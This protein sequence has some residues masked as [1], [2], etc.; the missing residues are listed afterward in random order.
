MYDIKNIDNTNLSSASRFQ[1]SSISAPYQEQF[2]SLEKRINPQTKVATRPFVPLPVTPNGQ[3]EE[4]SPFE[5]VLNSQSENASA[6][7]SVLERLDGKVDS[8]AAQLEKMYLD[9]KA[10]VSQPDLDLHQMIRNKCWGPEFDQKE[11]EIR[12]LKLS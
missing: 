3:T 11:A 7:N 5:A 12:S 10:R 2:P 8:I 6:Q 9:M 4:P 1:V